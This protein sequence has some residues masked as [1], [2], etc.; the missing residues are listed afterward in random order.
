MILCLEN[1]RPDDGHL[2]AESAFTLFPKA[3]FIRAN[4]LSFEEIVS[5]NFPHSS[6]TSFRYVC[7]GKQL[8]WLNKFNYI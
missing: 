4:F 8:Y 2:I 3:L 5:F 6:R 7:Q 1:S